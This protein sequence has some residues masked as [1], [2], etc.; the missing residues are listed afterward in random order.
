LEAL[1]HINSSISELRSSSMNHIIGVPLNSQYSMISSGTE[2]KVALGQISNSFI[3]RMSV[4]YMEGDFN[5]PI[6]YGYSLIGKDAQDQCFHL[7]HPH[8]SSVVVFPEHVHL[9]PDD[10]PLPRAALISNMETIIN[11]I[12]DADIKS[13]DKVAICGFGNIGALLAITLKDSHNVDCDII[14]IKE[15]NK[16]KAQS[17]GYTIHENDN[18]NIIFHTTGS[19]S[20]LQY[21]IDNLLPEGKVIELSWYGDQKVGLNL[22]D[23]FH[24]DR[25]QIISSQVS[26]IPKAYQ[27]QYDYQSRKDLA[28]QLLDNPRYDLLI[29]DYIPFKDSPRFF[30]DL[31]K[32]QQANGLIYLIEY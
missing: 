30:N 24:Y 23:R 22:G 28:I 25:L 5:L 32:G 7:M 11:A 6:K 17:L 4:P 16:L 26:T 18:Y 9:L 8:Q 29:A 19:E 31:R 13:G 14:E 1:W 20:G 3:K 15:W 10:L 12:W 2:G 27:D 21:C